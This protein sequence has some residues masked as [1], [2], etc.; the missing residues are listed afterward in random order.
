MSD[1]DFVSERVVVKE[2]EVQAERV[3]N[4]DIVCG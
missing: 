2:A 3:G 4:N 1:E